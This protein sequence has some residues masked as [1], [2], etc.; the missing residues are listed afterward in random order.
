MKTQHFFFVLIVLFS[1]SCE[2]RTADNKM[3]MEPAVMKSKA[4]SNEIKY[5]SVAVDSAYAEIPPSPAPINQASKKSEPEST[6]FTEKKIIK[7]GNIVIVSNEI[8]KSKKSLD[9]LLKQYKSYYENETLEHQRTYANYVLEIRIPNYNFEKFINALENGNNKIVEKQISTR[10]VTEEFVDGETR[11][12]NKKIYLERY[13]QLLSKA[14]NVKDMLEIEENIRNLQEEIESTEGRL[15]YL[16]DQ[17]SYS[18]LNLTIKDEIGYKFD[19]N[20]NYEGS[21]WERMKKSLFNGWN[22]I[23]DAV[24]FLLN[25]W[26][27]ILFFVAIYLFWRK[28][29]YKN[30]INFF[31]RKE[32]IDK[33]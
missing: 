31:K 33:K 20:E 3:Q 29:K 1:F 9:A 30:P 5:E 11:L 22:I 32:S 19:P 26:S 16:K 8:E 17:V 2:Q 6:S 13:Q 10:D 28:S 18:T 23:V 4:T 27:I 14:A 12:K 25:N 21:F 7:D 15:R 24:L